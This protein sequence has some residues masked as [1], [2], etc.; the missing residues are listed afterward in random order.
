MVKKSRKVI[1]DNE[2]KVQLRQAYNYINKGSLQ[3]AEKVKSKILASIK[4]D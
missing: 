1:I 2:A 3:N 4:T